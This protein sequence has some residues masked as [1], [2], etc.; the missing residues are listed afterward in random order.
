MARPGLLFVE[1]TNATLFR[2]ALLMAI[3]KSVWRVELVREEPKISAKGKS[4]FF[5]G[6]P[7]K[8]DSELYR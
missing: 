5:Q 3:S 4:D 2:L 6:D 1:Q 7:Q 8:A